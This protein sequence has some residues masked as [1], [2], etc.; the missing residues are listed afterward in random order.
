MLL[1]LIVPLRASHRCREKWILSKP[2]LPFLREKR[3]ERRQVISLLLV[4][5]P[6]PTTGGKQRQAKADLENA[7]TALHGS[8]SAYRAPRFS[9]NMTFPVEAPEQAISGRPSPFMSAILQSAPDTPPSLITV[10]VHCL[11]ESSSA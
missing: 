2:E 5:R 8:S 9:N 11:P 3:V 4:A 6:M 10:R 7:T 1:Q